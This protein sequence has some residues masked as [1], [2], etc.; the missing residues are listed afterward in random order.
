MKDFKVS[1]EKLTDVNLMR[2]AC[3][4]T[5]NG[6]S[7]Q[8]LLSMY[9][10]EHSP[11]RT[12]MFWVT[13]TNIPL[14][15]STHLLRHHVGSI[16]FQLTCRD[17]R[18]GGN[19]DVAGRIDA[20]ID[21]LEILGSSISIGGS[22]IEA[23]KII[24]WAYDELRWLRD[25]SDR[26]TPVKL[27]LCLN[28]QSLIDMSKLRLCKQSHRDTIKVFTVLKEQIK[29]VDPELAALMVPKCIYRNGL[30][31]E[32]MCCGYN[33]TQAFETELNNYLNNFNKKQIALKERD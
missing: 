28:A 32:P 19:P 29:E 27:G 18:K 16:P 13:F 9:K 17:D 8:T 7:Q 10:S 2:S 6:N 31:G 5:F 26:Q 3:E 12:Q 24:E 14:F 15:V 33:S 22:I 25:N 1:V 21:K 20:I 30:C 11:A 4:M 23:H